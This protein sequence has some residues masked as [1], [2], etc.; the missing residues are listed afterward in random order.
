MCNKTSWTALAGLAMSAIVVAQEPAYP[1]GYVRWNSDHIQEVADEL[2]ARLGDRSMIFETIGNYDGHSVYLVLRGKTGQAEMHET[3]SDVQIGVRGTATLVVGG[4]IIDASSLPRKQVRGAAISGGQRQL[5][6][7][8]DLIHIPP[9][10]AHQLLID[11]GAPYM[12]L[13]FKI[14]EEPLGNAE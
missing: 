13:L 5:T 7:P 6:A 10:V 4:D 3:E 1:D 2:E 8:G 12:Y 9:G 14:D 11:Q